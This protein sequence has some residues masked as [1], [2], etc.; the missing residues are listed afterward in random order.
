MY[1]FSALELAG[2]AIALDEEE[3][4][5]KRRRFWV[6][7]MLVKSEGEYNTLYPHLIDDEEK[8]FNY[9]RMPKGTFEYILSKIGSDIMKE[10]T[11]FRES[12]SSRERLA[13]CLSLSMF[14]IS[15]ALIVSLTVTVTGVERK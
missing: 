10:D 14:K 12:I 2:I 9:F 7:P 1:D 6:H 3:G 13:V 5:R 4:E 8:F 11:Y 15:F